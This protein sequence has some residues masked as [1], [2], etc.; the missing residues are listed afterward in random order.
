M[1][2]LL[3]ALRT[4]WTRLTTALARAGRRVYLFLLA[5][6]ERVRHRWGH[7]SSFRRTLSTAITAIT[8][9]AI[10]HP[11]LSA[12]LGALLNERTTRPAFTRFDPDD[13]DEDDDYPTGGW[14]PAS[15][16]LWDSLA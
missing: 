13:P 14:P 16:R 2:R 10:P 15:R 7:D 3:H 9:T 1:T 8:A 11:A 5:G 4:F 6:T 12:A